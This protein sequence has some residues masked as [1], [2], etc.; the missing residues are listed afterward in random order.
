MRPWRPLCIQGA[1]LAMLIGSLAGCSGKAE[2]GEE[3][4]GGSRAGTREGR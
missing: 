2:I 3:L 1:L 4:A